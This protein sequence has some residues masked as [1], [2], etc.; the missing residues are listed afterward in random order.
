MV[1]YER[2]Y[3]LKINLIGIVGNTELQYSDMLENIHVKK[4]KTITHNRNINLSAH[5]CLAF[6]LQKSL[7]C[8]SR[9]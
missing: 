7:T 4:V 2:T 8:K 6:H 5:K 3:T 1:L 9:F